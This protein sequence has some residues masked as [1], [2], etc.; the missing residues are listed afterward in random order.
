MA[1]ETSSSYGR[2]RRKRAMH[3]RPL[4]NHP[5]ERAFKDL[6]R[7][8]IRELRGQRRPCPSSEELV[9]FHENR[10][11]VEETERVRD[12]VEACGLCDVQLGRLETAGRPRGRSTWQA[13]RT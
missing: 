6:L 1:G 8:G 7:H 5:D 9:A 13:I 12:H 3:E 2:T 4:P 11:A 10:L